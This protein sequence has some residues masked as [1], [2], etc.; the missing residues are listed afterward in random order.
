MMCSVAQQSAEKIDRFRAHAGSV[1]LRLLHQED[2]PVPN[3]P[4]REEL[5]RI[6]ARYLCPCGRS[7]I[8]YITRQQL[9]PYRI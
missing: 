7:H 3:I 5:E 1:F 4:H 2:P 6:F 9:V 8:Y